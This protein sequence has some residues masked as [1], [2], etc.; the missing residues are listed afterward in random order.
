MN[1]QNVNQWL[2]IL[3]NAGVVIGIIFLII[4]VRQNDQIIV[5]EQ[6]LREASAFAQI[7]QQ[8][9]EKS[10]MFASTP[11]IAELWGRHLNDR[12]TKFSQA[13]L[14]MMEQETQQDA[15]LVHVAYRFWIAGHLPGPA[16][17]KM[18]ENVGEM[19]IASMEPENL[20]AKLQM[21]ALTN[22]P[23]D[24]LDHFDLND[25]P[26]EHLNVSAFRA[27]Q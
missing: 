14:I 10:R 24:F 5:G 23:D 19:K 6:E 4:E 18:E 22:M 11:I 13:E 2:S 25:F 27:I 16:W 20:R 3:A 15:R 26:R 7:E 12:S 21:R 1:M 8:Y 17:G 9:L